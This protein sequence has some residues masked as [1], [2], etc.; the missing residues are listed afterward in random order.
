[1]SHEGG[2]ANIPPTEGIELRKLMNGIPIDISSF[3]EISLTL[4]DVVYTHHKQDTVIGNLNPAV[5]QI[6]FDRKLVELIDIRITDYASLSPEQTGRINRT[7]ERRSDL[8][9]FIHK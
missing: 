7:P 1:M 3:L 8:Y 5:V 2:L 4:V 9:S 6:Q